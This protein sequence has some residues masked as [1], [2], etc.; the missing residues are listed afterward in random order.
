MRDYEALMSIST[1]SVWK[2]G[3]IGGPERTLSRHDRRLSDETKIPGGMPVYLRDD[4]RHALAGGDGFDQLMAISGNVYREAPARRTLRFERAGR[5]YFLKIHTG[6]GWREIF[7]NL[8]YARLP[9]LGARNEWRG[10]RRLQRLGI[11]TLRIA[12]YG[13]T[14]RNPA[15]RHSFIIT[16]EISDAVSLDEFCERWTTRPPRASG[17][18]RYKRWLIAKVAKITRTIHASG[19]NH[20]DLY[21]CHFLLKSDPDTD[22]RRP[23]DSRIYLIDL[24][25]MQIRRRTPLRW[26]IKDLAGLYFSTMD[27]RFTVRDY[28]RFISVYRNRPVREILQ[29]EH[30]FWRRVHHRAARVYRAEQ[31]RAHRHA[32][33]SV[34]PAQGVCRHAIP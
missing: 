2:H 33:R 23:A 32:A 18:V 26:I 21:L 9:V 31:R 28:L 29:G 1:T 34:R 12:G 6:V 13:A 14:G 16:D 10:I 30:G 7:K 11:D 27:M 19:A 3:L 20:R 4:L 17:D 8:T 5:G 15:R 25:R 24:H 22:R